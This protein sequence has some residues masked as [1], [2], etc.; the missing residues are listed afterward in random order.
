MQDVLS[1]SHG[2]SNPQNVVKATFDALF[3]LRDAKRVAQERG[4]SIDKVF[5][6]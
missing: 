1:K 3:K 5:N 2:S 6:G 4:V